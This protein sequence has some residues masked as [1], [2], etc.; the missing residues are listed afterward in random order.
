M[1]SI[2][3]KYMFYRETFPSM[4]GCQ[5]LSLLWSCLSS[6]C[7]PEA[8]RSPCCQSGRLRSSVRL[9]AAIRWLISHSFLSYT[10]KI[11]QTSSNC[12]LEDCQVPNVGKFSPSVNECQEWHLPQKQGIS[13]EKN[14]LLCTNCHLPFLMVQSGIWPHLHKHTDQLN[15]IKKNK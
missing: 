2:G 4:F 9:L 14:R 13:C 7:W 15:K 6:V 10:L 11:L 1:Y 8:M 5:L 12:L 3:Q